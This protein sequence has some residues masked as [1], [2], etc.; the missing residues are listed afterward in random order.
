MFCYAVF[1]NYYYVLSFPDEKRYHQV[2]NRVSR[3]GIRSVTKHNQTMC[4]L[5][6]RHAFNSSLSG[7]VN[8]YTMYDMEYTM[9][10]LAE[11]FWITEALIHHTYVFQSYILH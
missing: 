7:K 5:P 10:Y 2:C 11:R 1:Q 6:G 8:T 4:F 3:V 9:V